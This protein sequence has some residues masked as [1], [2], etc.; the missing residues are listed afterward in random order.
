MLSKDAFLNAMENWANVYMFRS[1]SAY[2]DY[3]K[4]TGISM[5]QA[6]ALTYIHYHGP[7]KISEICTYMMVSPAAAS[8]MVDRLEKQE[9]VK[10]IADP[11]DR[12]VRKVMLSQ[13]GERFVA[14]SIESRKEWTRNIPESVS[15]EQLDQIS[16]ALQLLTSVYQQ[17][18]GQES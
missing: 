10:R 9:L 12:R 13:Q 17:E 4:T 2:F 18:W 8:Q 1:L 3:L 5:Q 7:S 6:Y 11:T 15:E 14:L 16:A